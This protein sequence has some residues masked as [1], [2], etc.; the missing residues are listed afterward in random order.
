MP[1]GTEVDISAGHIVLDGFPVLRERAQHPPLLG[2]CLLWPRS[3]ISANAELLFVFSFFITL[4]SFGLVPC[5]RLSWLLASFWTQINIVHRIISCRNILSQ[6]YSIWRL[7]P[8][9]TSNVQ[10]ADAACIA[11]FGQLILRKI[12]K[13]YCCQM[14]DFKAKIDFGWGSAPDSSGPTLI[15]TVCCITNSSLEIFV[16]NIASV[17]QS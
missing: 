9:T 8:I 7:T 13:K 6:S 12:I 10:T 17:G 3:P 2:P 14:S 1:L 5:G 4:S 11:T 16:H 15:M